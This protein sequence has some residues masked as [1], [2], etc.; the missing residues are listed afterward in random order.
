MWVIGGVQWLERVRH[1]YDLGNQTWTCEQETHH[2][3]TSLIE[4][5]STSA[6]HVFTTM[7]CSSVCLA[8]FPLPIYSTE[9]LFPT[10]L[11]PM[12]GTRVG[13]PVPW[14]QIWFRRCL[15]CIPNASVP[16]AMENVL[17]APRNPEAGGRY[18]ALFTS[19]VQ[20][21]LKVA[22]RRD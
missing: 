5:R 9:M 22:S 13:T 8:L 21:N 12:P 7:T 2:I 11:L 16:A 20:M 19:L 4:M 15:A 3:S 6:T 10:E 18:V 17:S 1:Y 14:R